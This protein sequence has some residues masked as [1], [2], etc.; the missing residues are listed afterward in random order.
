MPVGLHILSGF[1][2]GRSQRSQGE[3]ARRYQSLAEQQRTSVNLKLVQS[4]NSLYDLIFG[5]ALDRH[6]QV[7]IVFA[8]NEI[9]WIPF[10]LEQWDYHYKR[11]GAGSTDTK[12]SRLPSEYFH[13]QVY[14]TFF[15]DAVGGRLLSWW[16]HDIHRLVDDAPTELDLRRLPTSEGQ[17]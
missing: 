14:A 9:G 6:P 16:G 7:K 11:H 15:N 12:M 4:L 8:E 10:V 5:G 3:G 17:G 13:D 2:Y 1:G